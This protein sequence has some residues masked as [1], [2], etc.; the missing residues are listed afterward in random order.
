MPFVRAKTIAENTY[1]YLVES[2]RSGAT[3]RQKVLKYLGRVVPKE[4]AK[5]KKKT[6]KK[7]V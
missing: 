1:Y 7:R 6:K 2:R 3:V 4:Y 5:P